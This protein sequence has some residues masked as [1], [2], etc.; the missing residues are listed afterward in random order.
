MKSPFIIFKRTIFFAIIILIFFTTNCKESSYQNESPVSTTDSIMFW[1]EK[2]KSLPDS[3][4]QEAFNYAET[5]YQLS[6]KYPQSQSI[7]FE[8]YFNL[9]IQAE[10]VENY[11]LAMSSFRETENMKGKSRTENAGDIYTHIGFVANKQG[12]YDIAMEYFPKG[13]EIRAKSGDRKGEAFSYLNIGSVYQSERKYDEAKEHYEQSLKIYKQLNDEMGI[14]SC[15]NNLGGLYLD[16]FDIEDAIE[17][18]KKAEQIYLANQII[19]RLSVAY[20]NIGRAYNYIGESDSARVYYNKMLKTSQNPTAL[21]EAYLSIGLFFDENDYSDSAMYYYSKAIDIANN[22]K[23][24]RLQYEAL[25]KRAFLNAWQHNYREAYNDSEASRS[26]FDKVSNL[27][28]VKEFTQKSMQYEFTQQQQQQAFRN[29]IMRFSIIA[30]FVGILLIG[31]FGYAQFRRFVEK[32]KANALLAKQQEEITDSIWY[33]S[34]IQKASLPSKEFVD[35]VLSDYFIFYRPRDIVSGDFYWI[36]RI[37]NLIIVGVA[38]CTGHGVPGAF[39]SML[40]ISSLNL[41]TTNMEM[42][43]A[44]EILNS[45]RHDVI[46]TLNPEGCTDCL[47]DG[48]D[49]SLAIIDTEKKEIEFAGAYNSLYLIHNG[50]LFE[51]KADRMP[52]G[53]YDKDHVPFTATRFGYEKNDVI[54]MFSDGYSDQFGGADNSKYKSKN[55]KNLVTSNSK[56]PMGE[57]SRLLEQAHL[58]WRGDSPQI[59]DILV[60]GIR[61]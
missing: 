8:I 46:K 60:V 50:E 39:V 5:A 6:M 58:D 44:D 19:D 29:R 57:Q 12:R 9:G 42:P 51:K 7:L 10:K 32:K 16:Q 23:L 53:V 28:T 2:S 38:D 34:M 55:F 52:V 31:A 59:D 1:L 4:A 36:N 49:I 25:E 20:D 33:A 47:K 24:Y 54:Y 21:A 17:F 26:A 35:S 61:L 43:K 37:H 45:L 41:I 13:L 3:M 11:D 56:K 48:M 30:L 15:Y 22:L 18:F 27:K 14:A 40:G